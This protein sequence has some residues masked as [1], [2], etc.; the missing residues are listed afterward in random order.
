MNQITSAAK[1]LQ[2]GINN[3]TSLNWSMHYSTYLIIEIC[4]PLK[5]QTGISDP[6]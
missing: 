3:K 5:L 6:L 2:Q 1:N 4:T